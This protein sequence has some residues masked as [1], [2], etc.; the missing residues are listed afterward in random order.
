MGGIWTMEGAFLF[1]YGS[2]AL[3]QQNVFRVQPG[4]LSVHIEI[5][6]KLRSEEQTM[7]GAAKMKHPQ[8]VSFFNV[9][10]FVNC[11]FAGRNFGHAHRHHTHQ[12]YI[13]VIR[14]NKYQSTCGKFGDKTL[15][16]I[17]SCRIKALR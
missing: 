4:F 7:R 3:V 5:K 8:L 16:L 9:L 17:F 12:A 13:V 14:F 2:N 11:Y 15:R 6:C 1:S 10:S